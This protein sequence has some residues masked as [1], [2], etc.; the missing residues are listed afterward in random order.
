MW[1]KQRVSALRDV[2]RD[3]LAAREVGCGQISLQC[4]SYE[5]KIAPSAREPVSFTRSA[6]CPDIRT[7][8]HPPV[9]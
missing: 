9:S 7:G 6:V 1:V 8:I 3:D 4:A 2:Q 5:I